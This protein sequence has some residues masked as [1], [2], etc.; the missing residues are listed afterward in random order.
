MLLHGGTLA[1]LHQHFVCI[2]LLK[3]NRRTAGRTRNRRGRPQDQERNLAYT[4]RKLHNMEREKVSN[5]NLLLQASIFRFYLRKF[6]GGVDREFVEGFDAPANL[7][8]LFREAA[9]LKSQGNAAYQRNDIEAQCT[10]ALE[11][12][13]GCG[14][15]HLIHV[16]SDPADGSANCSQPLAG[17]SAALEPSHPEACTGRD[18]DQSA[19]E[20]NHHVGSC[21]IFVCC[22]ARHCVPQQ[23]YCKL[24]RLI[25][26]PSDRSFKTGNPVARTSF[27]GFL[28][29]SSFARIVT[30]DRFKRESFQDPSLT[31]F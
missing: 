26:S 17:S 20:D 3:C 7:L 4:T 8:A 1:L 15:P 27:L 25:S 31:E 13:L 19:S 12:L 18:D 5:R 6:S 30:F 9:Q 23:L 16:P 29:F 28:M 14:R 22:R 2:T 21:W 10:G 11:G 24:Q